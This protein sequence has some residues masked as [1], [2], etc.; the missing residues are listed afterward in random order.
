MYIKMLAISV[1]LFPSLALVL[2]VFLVLFHYILLHFRKTFLKMSWLTRAFGTTVQRLSEFSFILIIKGGYGRA[3]KWGIQDV[4]DWWEARHKF[5][6]E[7]TST[8]IFGH[9]RSCV[10]FRYPY[11]VLSCLCQWRRQLRMIRMILNESCIYKTW[12]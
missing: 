6:V 10:S 1:H 2:S 4:G 7:F 3:V 5:R 9:C 11:K 8:L 12:E